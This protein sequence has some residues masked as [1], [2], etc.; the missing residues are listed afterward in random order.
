MTRNLTTPERLAV[1]ESLNVNLQ[2]D[3]TEIKRDVKELA[4]IQ[5]SLATDLATKT[6]SIATDLAAKTATLATNLAVS[7]SAD[8]A[9]GQARASTGIWVRSVVPWFL[10]G[11][12]TLVTFLVAIGAF[13][14]TST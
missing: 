9:T 3:V 7:Q 14:G 2:A 6:A 10:A 8:S 12:G 1:L 13:S 11:M 4:K 5:S